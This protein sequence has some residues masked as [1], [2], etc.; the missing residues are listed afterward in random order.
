M[1]LNLMRQALMFRDTEGAASA[2]IKS[3]PLLENYFFDL[4]GD[5][6]LADEELLPNWW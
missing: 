6:E 4:M 2:I 1:D 5:A 3:Y